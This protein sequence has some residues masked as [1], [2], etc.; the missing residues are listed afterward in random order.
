M[1]LISMLV[2]VILVVGVVYWML[3]TARK[4]QFPIRYE[5]WYDELKDGSF[6]KYM[7]PKDFCLLCFVTQCSVMVSLITVVLLNHS[8]WNIIIVIPCSAAYVIYLDNMIQ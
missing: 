3:L 4:H 5:N 2:Q 8:F 7:L 1:I 6:V